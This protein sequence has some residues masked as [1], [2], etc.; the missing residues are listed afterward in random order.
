M[1]EQATSPTLLRTVSVLRALRGELCNLDESALNMVVRSYGHH[2]NAV[3][4]LVE[5]DTVSELEDLVP[6]ISL[7][8]SIDEVR[9]GVSALEAWLTSYL[10]SLQV[11]ELA[12]QLAARADKAIAAALEVFDDGDQ[13]VI[14]QYL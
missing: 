12:K 13:P 4:E 10:E 5:I 11:R 3:C 1:D 7:G 6:S 2:R 9:V 8:S 14:G